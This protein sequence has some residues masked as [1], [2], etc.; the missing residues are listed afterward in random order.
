MSSHT[1]CRHGRDQE[2]S[3]TDSWNLDRLLRD[4][5]ARRQHPAVIAFAENGVAAWDSE[6]VADKALRLARG[7]HDIGLEPGERVALWAPNSPAWIVAALAVLAAGAV[8]VPIDD[9]GDAEQL[10]AALVSCAARLVFTTAHH[11]EGC[12]DILRERTARVILVDEAECT[13]QH[14]MGWLSLLGERAEHPTAPAPGAPALLSWT[15]GTTGSPK[16]FQLTY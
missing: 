12:G 8:L 6:T 9:L 11:L 13:G 16:A 4:L 10:D 1:F 2:L 7:L 5:A 15:S 3:V 14:G